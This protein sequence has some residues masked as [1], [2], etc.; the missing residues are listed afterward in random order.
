[1][2]IATITVSPTTL[3]GAMHYCEILIFFGFVF[4]SCNA[5]YNTEAPYY[6]SIPRSVITLNAMGMVENS[7]FIVDIVRLEEVA[8]FLNLALFRFVRRPS[9]KTGNPSG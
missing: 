9:Q 4:L 2:I 6:L 1:M 7:I 8:G 5:H 3:S